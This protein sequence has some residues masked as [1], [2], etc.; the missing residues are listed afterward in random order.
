MGGTDEFPTKFIKLNQSVDSPAGA[1]T[2][3]PHQDE[4]FA[5][6][7]DTSLEAKSLNI[8]SANLICHETW[9]LHIRQI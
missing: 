9:R 6:I 1:R 4:E 2:P 5:L 7:D 8:V 3:F